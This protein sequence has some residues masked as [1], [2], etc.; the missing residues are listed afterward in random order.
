MM[1]WN[2]YAFAKSYT[3]CGLSFHRGYEFLSHAKMVTSW[4]L[5]ASQRAWRSTRGSGAHP[6]VTTK[7]M[8]AIV[9][10]SESVCKNFNTT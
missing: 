2:Q 7:Q 5:S 1:P 6:L 4:P 9:L 3:R 8:L 10:T